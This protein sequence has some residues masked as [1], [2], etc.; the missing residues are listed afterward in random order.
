MGAS[1]GVRGLLREIA[2]GSQ[3][4]P[5]YSVS[6]QIQVMAVDDGTTVFAKTTTALGSPTN[7]LDKVFDGTPSEATD[8]TSATV[9]HTTTLATT[10]FNTFTVKRIS[11]HADTTS[12]VTG[13]STTFVCGVDSQSLLKTSDFTLAIT[14]KIKAV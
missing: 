8:S 6:R 5:T 12:N 2:Q 9:T 4:T 10:E 7:E 3:S 1:F 13:S 11:L 14:L